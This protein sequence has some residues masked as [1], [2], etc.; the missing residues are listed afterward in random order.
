MPPGAQPKR[1]DTLYTLLLSA[2]LTSAG[3]GTTPAGR[4][5]GFIA[6]P[7]ATLDKSTSYFASLISVAFGWFYSQHN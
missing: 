6:S 4:L 5:P 1:Q 2:R 7:S 3:I